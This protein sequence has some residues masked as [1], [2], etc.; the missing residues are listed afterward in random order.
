MRDLDTFERHVRQGGT[1]QLH[2]GI[3]EAAGIAN[4]SV[5][6][7]HC[8]RTKNVNGGELRSGWPKCCRETM[9]LDRPS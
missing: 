5:T 8:G 1:G 9:S 6:C 3:A 4:G 7:R 2:G